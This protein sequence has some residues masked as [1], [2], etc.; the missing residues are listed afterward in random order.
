MSGVFGIFETGENNNISQNINRMAALLNHFDWTVCEAD[1]INQ[2]VALGRA[3]INIFNK[4]SQPVYNFEKNI[5]LVLSGEIYNLEQFPPNPE[6]NTSLE[7]YLLW[8]YETQGLSFISKLKGVFILALWDG[9]KKQIV[10]ANDYMGFYP[11]YYSLQNGK[12]IF[13]PEVKAIISHPHFNKKSDLTAMAQYFRFQHLLGHRTFFEDISMLPPATILVYEYETQKHSLETYWTFESI[14]FREKITFDEAV[15]EAG[16]LLK[17]A[18]RRYSEDELRPGVYLSGGLDSRTILGFMEHRP[19]STICYG[20]RDSMDVIYGER[21]ARLA[22][23]DHHWFDMREGKWVLDYI[24]R[25]LDLTE[26]FHSWIH[27]HGIST[28]DEARQWMDVNL[29]GWCG[30]TVMGGKD[31]IEPQQIYAVDNLALVNRLFYLFNQKYTWPSITESEEKLLYQ[32]N[33]LKKVCGLAFD[34]F[35]EE[36]EPFSNVRKDIRGEAFYIRTNLR[37]LT[38]NMLA[39]YR[40]HIEVRIPFFDYDLIQFLYSIPAEVR[41][42]KKMYWAMIQRELPRYALIPNSNDELLPL[43]T[44]AL[45]EMNDLSLKL[46]RRITKYSHQK[47]F[48]SRK[49]LYADYENYLRRD[50]QKWAEDIL[51]DSRTIDRGIYNPDFLRTLMNRHLSGNEEWTIGK[52]API[53]T[54]EM[55]LRKYFD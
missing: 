17:K 20:D 42:V 31:S 33:T 48:P 23:S 22:G 10:L 40:G 55:M 34:S 37:R 47:L 6:Q 32:D 44:P 19:V 39:I 7:K 15:S 43:Y 30:G 29:I 21:I 26:G 5:A 27:S 38:Q 1:V 53:I 11:T 46:R 51:Y 41:G 16:R 14:P 12:F 4:T 50:L 52:I 3:G 24:D 49:T 36:F 54:Y 28:L 18:V 25:H 35:R 9:R 45:R 2:R 13:A 8:L